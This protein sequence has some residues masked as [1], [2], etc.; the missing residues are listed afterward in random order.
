MTVRSTASAQSSTRPASSSND[1]TPEEL[2]AARIELGCSQGEF[3][4]LVRV[5]SDRTVR[6]WETGERPIPGPVAVLLDLLRHIPAVRQRLGLG[7]KE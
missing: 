2:R 3:A 4:D 1:V 5:E 7:S 6:R